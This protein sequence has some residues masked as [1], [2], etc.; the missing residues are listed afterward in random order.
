LERYIVERRP[1][2]PRVLLLHGLT[3]SPVELWPLAEGLAEAGWRVELPLWPGHGA[4]PDVLARTTP[5]ELLSAART[6]GSE[7]ADAVVGFSMGG[8]LAFVTAASAARP[9]PLVLLAPA[10]TMAGSAKLFDRLGTL[11]W[12]PSSVLLDKGSGEQTG[13]AL[14]DTSLDQPGRT[15]MASAPRLVPVRYERVP[16]IWARH[17]RT[18]RHAAHAAA[19]ALGGRALAL[20]GTGDRTADASSLDRLPSWSPSVAWDC[21]RIAGAPHQLATSPWRGLVTDAVATF[22]ASAA[23]NALHGG[24]V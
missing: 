19:G 10:V 18:I 23:G 15:A 17:L 3:G 8:L 9:M 21:R 12:L 2:G 13:H 7:D 6:L 24:L 1:G 20:H 5:V 16:L 4:S 22:L 11:P 14:P